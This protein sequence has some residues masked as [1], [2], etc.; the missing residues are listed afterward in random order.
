MSRKFAKDKYEIVKSALDSQTTEFVYNYFMIKRQVYDTF[1]EYNYL[2]PYDTDFG[3]YKDDQVPGTYSVYGDIVMET[4]LLKLQPVMEKYVGLSLV[5]TVSYARIYKKGDELKR[6]KDRPSC[7]I[8][9][10]LNLGGDPWPIF[11]DPTGKDN[12]INEFK[13]I[14][15][16][17]AHKGRKYL[18]KTGDMFLYRGC[19]LEHWREEFD[20][21]HCAQVFLHY[22]HADG[23][24]GKSNL[25]DKRKHVG[26]PSWFAEK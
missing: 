3:T 17:D 22:N 16:P 21:D 7:E 15:K 5:P 18:L 1:L 14:H 4:L 25:F 10:T 2:S 8:S 24:Y 6:H 11:V 23:P 26:L 12:V 9:A 20:G 13:K 19:E